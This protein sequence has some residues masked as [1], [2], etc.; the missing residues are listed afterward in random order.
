MIRF[1]KIR[2]I[3][4]AVSSKFVRYSA[5]EWKTY[6]DSRMVLYR[7]THKMWVISNDSDPLCVIGTIKKSFLGCGIEIY[8]FLCEAGQ[9]QLKSLV[10]FLRKAFRR[11]VKLY[12]IVT[13]SIDVSFELGQRFIKFFGFAEEQHEFTA[14]ETTFKH[15]YL[16]A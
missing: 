9:K 10:K 15:F 2:V 13:V 14:G 6:Y 4:N 1:K 8:F 16:R 5:M 3:S 11:V 7:R 12:K